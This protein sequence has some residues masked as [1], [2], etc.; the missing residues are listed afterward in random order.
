[1]LTPLAPW[2]ALAGTDTTVT[3]IPIAAAI[4]LPQT[5][6]VIPV[7]GSL[8]VYDMLLAGVLSLTTGTPVAGAATAAL[9]VRTFKLLVSLGCG[10]VTTRFLHDV[11]A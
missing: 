8:G 1:M 4:S 9:I 7:P 5:T 6:N 10:G 11:R 2:V 3:L